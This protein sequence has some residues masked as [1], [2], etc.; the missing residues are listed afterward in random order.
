MR[1]RLI[2]AV[3]IALLFAREARADIGGAMS[4]Y[5]NGDYA[6]AVEKLAPLTQQANREALRLMGEMHENG[7]GVPQNDTLAW[8]YYQRAA[9][10][11]DVESQYRL[12]QMH[13]GGRGVPQSYAEASKWYQRASLTGHAGAKAKLGKLT[14]AGRG[15]KVSFSKGLSLI[16]EAALSGEPEAEALLEDLERRGFAKAS[17]S[18]DQAPPDAESADVLAKAQQMIR[19]MSAPF[20]LGPKLNLGNAAFIARNAQGGWTV[21]LPKP[22]IPQ[23]DGASWRGASIRL[24]L[25]KSDDDLYRIRITLPTVWRFV[26]ALGREG[27]RLEIG[28][29]SVNG[30]WSAKLGQWTHSDTVLSAI[31]IASPE[32]KGSIDSLAT[33]SNLTPALEGKGH[34]QV[35]TLQ[36]KKIAFGDAKTTGFSVQAVE[37]SSRIASLELE[38]FRVLSGQGGDASLDNLAP[39]ATSVDNR[40]K[41]SDVKLSGLG[42]EDIL[43]INAF[44]VTMGAM[45]MDTAASTLKAGITASGI[46]AKQPTGVSP[47]PLPLGT[48]PEKL[49]LRL[50]WER[51]PLRDLTN[52]LATLWLN[53]GGTK[54]QTSTQASLA[55]TLMD[56]LA[57]AMDV[58]VDAGT[59]I[60]IED[61]SASA[62]D[63][64]IDAKGSFQPEK[65]KAQPFSGK[66]TITSRGLDNLIKSLDDGTNLAAVMLDGLRRTSPPKKDSAGNDVFEVTFGADG[67]IDINGQRWSQP[68]ASAKQGNKPIPL[69]KKK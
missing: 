20:P 69:T 30:I 47:L 33:Y 50:S 34:D 32:G 6:L 14:L 62:P 35:Q 7:R 21:T 56:S 4:A 36:I 11:G 10:G 57:T 27:G 38:T 23:S 54:R 63:W 28:Q 53:Q 41:L 55:D 1:L 42:G 39:L 22:A 40:F 59:E 66:I 18:Q 16:Q 51:L 48:L 2:L 8:S 3:L 49:S 37:A 17:Q 26:S 52:Q 45:G 24:A 68:E 5:A 58:L 9:L 19:A 31:A 25:S 15:G 64:G 44:E 43:S 60:R 61:I 13:E 65:A 12:G 67:A 46:A 29:Q